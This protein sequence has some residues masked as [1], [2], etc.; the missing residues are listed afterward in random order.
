[1][2]RIQKL[3]ANHGDKETAG[4]LG[5]IYSFLDPDQFFNFNGSYLKYHLPPWYNRSVC[6][7]IHWTIFFSKHTTDFMLSIVYSLLL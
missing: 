6:D 2:F 7:W 5:I 1:M 3:G 4:N